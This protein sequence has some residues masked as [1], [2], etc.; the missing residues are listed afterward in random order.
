MIDSSLNFLPGQ[1]IMLTLT[2][3]DSKQYASLTINNR[4]NRFR[5]FFNDN[6]RPHLDALG[7]HTY[8]MEISE[9]T[10]SDGRRYP[11]LHHHIIMEIQ[12]PIRMLLDNGS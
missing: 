3:P 5:Q 10:A 11:R 1:D 9:P 2:Y 8:S 12:K 7:H 4:L 6:I